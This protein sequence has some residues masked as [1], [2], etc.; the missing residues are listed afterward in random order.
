VWDANKID[1]IGVTGVLRSFH[2][3][4]TMKIPFEDEIKWC[5]ERG[6]RFYGSLHTKTAKEIAKN[7][8][9]KMVRLLSVLESELMLEDLRA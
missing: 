6:L 9:E 2:W 5:C 4:G 8:H 7:R 3:A 1:L